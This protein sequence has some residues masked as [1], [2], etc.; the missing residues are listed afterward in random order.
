MAKVL[1]ACDITVRTTDR[2][3]SMRHRL[4]LVRRQAREE[5]PTAGS[6]WTVSNPDSRSIAEAVTTTH[7]ARLVT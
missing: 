5:W 7:Q 6:T 3:H 4:P 1:C 2:H